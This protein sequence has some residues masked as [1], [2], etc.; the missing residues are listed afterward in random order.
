MEFPSAEEA[1]AFAP[2]AWFGREITED[3]RFSYGTLA[4]ADGGE[5]LRKLLDETD[6]HP[7]ELSI[8]FERCNKQGKIFAIANRL[9]YDIESYAERY[10]KAELVAGSGD[11]DYSY[12]QI[13]SPSYS[14]DLIED[15]ELQSEELTNAKYSNGE[16]YWIGFFYKYISLA[17]SIRGE[18][19]LEK[20]PFSKMHELYQ[21]FNALPKETAGK[22]LLALLS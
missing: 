15:E 6:A 1:A 18:A 8:P 17:L 9:G 3:P 11:E 4:K 21:S 14:L 12:Y 5:Q 20:A 7:P 19:L 10:M 22:K 13:A 2:P 16:A